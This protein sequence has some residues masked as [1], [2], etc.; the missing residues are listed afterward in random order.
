MLISFLLSWFWL[1]LE[2]KSFPSKQW[3]GRSCV[4]W[5]AL[6]PF[7][8]WRLLL[9]VFLGCLLY[10]SFLLTLYALYIWVLDVVISYLWRLISSLL[11]TLCC[12]WAEQLNHNQLHEFLSYVNC[13]QRVYTWKKECYLFLKT[14]RVAFK[15]V[16]C[17]SFVFKSKRNFKPDQ[18][19]AGEIKYI[20]FCLKF[21]N[22]CSYASVSSWIPSVQFWKTVL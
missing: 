1:E 12:C 22:R 16:F 18:K 7:C 10:G 17:V 19:R 3:D 14:G 21:V 13:S 6:C 2:A 11:K 9:L 5:K 4:L 8:T 20:S 15:S